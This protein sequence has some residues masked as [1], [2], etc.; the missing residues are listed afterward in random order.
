MTTPLRPHMRS[1]KLRP[2]LRRRKL[3]PHLRRRQIQLDE[4]DTQVATVAEAIVVL[5]ATRSGADARGKGEL[6]GY[7][8]TVARRNPRSYVKILVHLLDAENKE[9]KRK[10]KAFS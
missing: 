4:A 9:E 5:A 2:H 1:R 8:A 3:R 10:A 7:F 6:S